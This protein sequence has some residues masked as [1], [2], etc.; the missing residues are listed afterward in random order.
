MI[1]G[2]LAA[3]AALNGILV[4][5]LRTGK[6]A[7]GAPVEFLGATARLRFVDTDCLTHVPLPVARIEGPATDT[8]SIQA[9][10]IFWAQTHD[11]REKLELARTA[12]MGQVGGVALRPVYHLVIRGGGG[13]I[14]QRILL[15]VGLAGSATP[16][17][18]PAMYKSNRSGS[19]RV[20]VLRCV[21]HGWMPS[22]CRVFQ[23]ALGHLPDVAFWQS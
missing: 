3:S 2:A 15:G 20:S 13:Q 19:G 10:R 5:E 6:S 22:S 16:K 4:F 14:K 1:E 11:L 8:S 9:R 17:Y 7:W 12:A 23:E 21:Y 18:G